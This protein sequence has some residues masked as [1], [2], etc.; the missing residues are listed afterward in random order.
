M[1]ECHITSKITLVV[2]ADIQLPD[3]EDVYMNI[4]LDTWSLKVQ[5]R[6]GVGTGRMRYLK[7][8]PRVFK[9]SIKGLQK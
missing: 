5:Q 8:I 3:S 4:K 2:L 6:K 1:E 9:N 7:T